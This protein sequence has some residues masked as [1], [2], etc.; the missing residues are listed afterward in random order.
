MS[1]LPVESSGAAANAESASSARKGPAAA[2]AKLAGRLAWA[3]RI[4]YVRFRFFAVLGAAFLVAGFWPTIRGW[5]D[6]LAIGAAV[7][8]GAESAD[9][10]YFCPMCPGVVSATASKCSVCNMELVRRHKQEAELLPNGVVAR[11]QLSPER[12]QLAGVKT[13]E[14]R[15]LPLRA[16]LRGLARALPPDAAR[17]EAPGVRLEVRLP[18]RR[19]AQVRAADVA[20]VFPDDGGTASLPAKVLPDSV[21][22]D[23][24]TGWLHVELEC[25]QGHDRLS[26]GDVVAVELQCLAAALG[27]EG[28]SPTAAPPYGPREAYYCHDH[29]DLL[30]LAPGDCPFDGLPLHKAALRDYETLEWRCPLHPGV[31]SAEPNATCEHCRG[32]PLVASVVSHLPDGMVLAIPESAVIDTGAIKIAFVEREPGMFDGVEVEVGAVCD[33]FYPVRRGLRGGQRVASAGAL[34]LDAETRLNPSLAAAYFGAGGKSAATGAGR[35]AT[36]GGHAGESALSPA[37]QAEIRR[38]ILEL[39]EKD[40]AAAMTQ[41]LCPVTG[42]PLGSMG[43]P[44]ALTVGDRRVF[45]C[46]AG[47]EAALRDNPAEYL[48][49]LP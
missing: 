49:K 26:A 25:E 20:F 40:R 14:V 17:A 4:A 5:W 16:R 21:K 11:M 9:T 43:K 23:A 48:S 7:R 36:H 6:A 45:I 8:P 29:A 18:R 41:R 38:R 32:L 24:E 15:P 27:G 33:G 44:I 47:C 12:L 19:L 13:V 39:P 2:S 34:L 1:A 10:E 46:C 22:V 31:A 35:D 28:K 30:R 42:A 3:W 37:Q